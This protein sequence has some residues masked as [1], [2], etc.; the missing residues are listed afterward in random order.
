MANAS[1]PRPAT[2]PISGERP[3]NWTLPNALT[4]LRIFLV[5]VLV[6]FLL[7]EYKLVGLGVFIIASLTD[8]FD[9]YLARTRKQITTLGQLLDPIADK[10]LITGAFISLVELDLAPAWMV[11]I[12]I[13]RELA[14]SG[15]RIVAADQGVKIPAS[16]LGKYKTT[17]QML[18]VILLILGPEILGEYFLLGEVGLWL[19]VALSLLSAGQYFANSWRVLGLGGGAT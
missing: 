10:L 12:I 7:T 4:A 15:L 9:G 2:S 1:Q 3:D 17:V 16:P 14:I 8:W 11:V 5:P 18:T 19:V 13:G 6:V